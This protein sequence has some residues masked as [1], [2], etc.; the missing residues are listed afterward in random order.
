M[1]LEVVALQQHWRRSLGILWVALFVVQ[2][3]FSL[4]MPFL[5]LYVQEM[6][7]V[8]AHAVELWSGAIF[9]AN[10]ITAAIFLPIWGAVADRVGRR[11]MM[12][13]AAFGMGLVVGFMGLATHPW[14][15]VLLRLLQGTT[16]G[17]VPA[18][19]AYMAGITPK[20]HT[21][22]VLGTLQ[23]GTTAG[24][25]IGPLVG[26]LLATFIGHRPIFFLTGL[27]CILGGVVILFFIPADKVS[28]TSRRERTSVIA[29]LRLVGRNP[30]LVAM[31]VVLM[32]TTFSAMNAEP[33]IPLYLQTLALPAG[34]LS[35]LSGLVFSAT[36]I[37]DILASPFLGRR[38]DRYGYKK[39][40]LISLA[41]S[42]VMYT[43]QAFAL[44]WWHVLI[45]RF[46][47]GIFMG[48]A[49]AAGNA[50]ISL[51]VP[52]TFQG[53]AFGVSMAA[54][55][56]GN[57]LGPVTGGA[58]SAW[59]GYRAVFPITGLLRMI[60]F[61]WVYIVIHEAPAPRRLGDEAAAAD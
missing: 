43:A 45:L 52:A 3:G 7:V 56:I 27:A 10:F 5:S 42:A 12:L 25:V 59:L 49:L 39:V 37:A 29:D 13:R 9:S 23:A 20:E 16:V 61:V 32:L 47:Q 34:Y 54:M 53:R 4:I 24:T 30:A 17:L 57:F 14:Q 36:G 1:S 58:I 55:Q 51:S 48:G 18:A 19:I 38:G 60:N 15:L 21:G 6:G 41:G 28:E 40:L 46:L 22:Y 11:A 50:L 26:G 8:S 31:M 2:V 44:T 35:F 33:I